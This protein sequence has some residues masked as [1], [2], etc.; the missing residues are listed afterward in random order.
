VRAGAARLVLNRDAAPERLAREIDALARDRTSLSSMAA[1]AR[2]AGKPEAAEAIARD[3]LS[4]SGL[5]E[6]ATER[7]AA[8]A[9]PEPSTER[10]PLVALG[11]D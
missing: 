8:P 6:P 1:A 10:T 11:A 3:L 9:G 5:V 7:D 4:L 2:A